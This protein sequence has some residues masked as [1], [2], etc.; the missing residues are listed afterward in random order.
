M[1]TKSKK[2]QP[3]PKQTFEL[4]TEAPLR[5]KPRTAAPE[6]GPAALTEAE[7]RERDRQTVLRLIEWLRTL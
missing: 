5:L 1:A 7:Q 2:T 3:K 6:Q 4:K